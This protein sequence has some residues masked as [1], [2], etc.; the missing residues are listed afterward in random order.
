MSNKKY[1]L[2]A[3]AANKKLE[4]MAFEVAEQNYNEKE[5][6]LAG[7][8]DNGV[9]LSKKIAAY[10]QNLYKGK[11]ELIEIEL[12]K[13]QP[14]EIIVHPPI[15]FSNRNVLIID[16]VANSGKTMLYALKPLLEK[17]P[18]RI[19]TMALV[20]RTHKLFPVDVDYVGISISTTMDEHIF[21]EVEGEELL[22]AYLEE[23][24]E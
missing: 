22:G 9:L 5:L 24:E 12:N 13:R 7:I 2:S 14:A 3:A 19:Q 10:L 15:D 18:A 6:V 21:V 8:K 16:D 17:H 23:S 20:E 4:R 1:I 11:V